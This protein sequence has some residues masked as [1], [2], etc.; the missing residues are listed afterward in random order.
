MVHVEMYA[1]IHKNHIGINSPRNA[2]I[3]PFIYSVQ[4]ENATT[5]AKMINLLMLV[6]DR[7]LIFKTSSK[8]MPN[9]LQ[10]NQDLNLLGVCLIT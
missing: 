5:G 1:Q 6:M 2:K 7:A 4:K 9:L 8:R 10:L 3:V